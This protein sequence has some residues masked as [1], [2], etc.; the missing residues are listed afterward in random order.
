MVKI[1]FPEEVE[2]ELALQAQQVKTN[3]S[4]PTIPP[5]GLSNQ[6][7]INSHIQ[8]P[9]E[10][11]QIQIQNEIQQPSKLSKIQLKAREDA[12]QKISSRLY[13]P[14]SPLTDEYRSKSGEIEE[15]LK[16]INERF[17][18]LKL[19]EDAKTADL[20][21]QAW[22]KYN[23]LAK[24]T[25]SDF[26]RPITTFLLFASAVY[27][28]MQ[29]TWF[30]LERENYVEHLEQKEAKLV[31]ELNTALL[32]QQDILNQYNNPLNK[33]KWYKFW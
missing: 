26:K 3:P 21:R 10:A 4:Y 31:T 27:M 20:Q 16:R 14:E 7:S 2:R 12:I 29:Y 33:K 22:L 9:T 11:S 23:H 5:N 18:K 28:T 15:R 6:A 8:K 24:P 17:Q 19:K 32:N 1:V 30:A 25:I 13:T